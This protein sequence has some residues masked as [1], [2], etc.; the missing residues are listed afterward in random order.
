MSAKNDKHS[1]EA[2]IWGW[3]KVNETGVKEDLGQSD[4]SITSDSPIY[5][6]RGDL[7]AANLWAIVCAA[8]GFAALCQ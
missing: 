2:K 1:N 6:E 8:R 4:D 5:L 3:E 7:M